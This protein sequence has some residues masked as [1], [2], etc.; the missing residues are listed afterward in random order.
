MAASAPHDPSNR[1]G[2]AASLW[3]PDSRSPS[4]LHP[5]LVDRRRAY[6]RFVPKNGTAL[7]DLVSSKLP[8]FEPMGMVA[9]PIEAANPLTGEDPFARLRPVVEVVNEDGSHPSEFSAT[10]PSA[11]PAGS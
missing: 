3:Q 11:A 4:V 10:A 1:A 8:A 5:C 9:R 2:R 7:P 6:S